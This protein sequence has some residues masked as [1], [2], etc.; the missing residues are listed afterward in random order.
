LKLHIESVEDRVEEVE[1]ENEDMLR[2]INLM[3]PIEDKCN[4]LDYKV[5]VQ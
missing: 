3:E 2:I 1:R 5:T 4:E